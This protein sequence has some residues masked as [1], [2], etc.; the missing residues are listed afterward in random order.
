MVFADAVAELQ[1]FR[2]V[3]VQKFGAHPDHKKLA[4]F[5]FGRELAQGSRCPFFAF[6]IKMNT[7]RLQILFV[8]ERRAGEDP[9]DCQ[10]QANLSKHEQTIAWARASTD[11]LVPGSLLGPRLLFFRQ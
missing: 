4:D 6:A 7:A 8:G 1:V 5:F 9:E 2:G 3:D 10:E 11:W